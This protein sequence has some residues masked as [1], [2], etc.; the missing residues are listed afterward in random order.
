[1]KKEAGIDKCVVFPFPQ[2]PFPKKYK[3]ANL[4]VASLKDPFISFYWV[5]PYYFRKNEVKVFA[6]KFDVKGFKLHPVFDGYYP[7]VEFLESIM[8]TS[9]ELNIP[10]LFHSLWGEFGAVNG[11]EKVAESFPRAEILISHLVGYEGI[12][13]ARRHDN[14]YLD[15]SYAPHPRRIEFAVKTLGAKR[16]VFASDFP[17]ADP[18]INLKIIGRAEISEKEKRLILGENAMQL[19]KIKY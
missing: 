10:V 9:T 1:M 4:K 16:I 8:R 17:Y 18:V 13:A 6:R 11:I 14:I 12:D 19:L 3:K 7:T 15:T 5:N 2:E